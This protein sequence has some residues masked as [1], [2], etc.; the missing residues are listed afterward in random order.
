MVKMAMVLEGG[1]VVEVKALARGRP[2]VPT[3]VQ[4]GGGGLI[5]GC[6]IPEKLKTKGRRRYAP[7]SSG[8]GARA[9]GRWEALPWMGLGDGVRRLLEG[10][11]DQQE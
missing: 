2:G 5:V 7:R 4:K 9:W 11:A 10:V 1:D 8:E 6:V 3:V